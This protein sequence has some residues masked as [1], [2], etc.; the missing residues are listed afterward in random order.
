MDCF[1]IESSLSAGSPYEAGYR[2]GFVKAREM[3]AKVARSWA[4]RREIT[5]ADDI[6]EVGEEE[7]TP[8]SVS[9]K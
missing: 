6:L 4:D 8:S 5:D 3:A 7:V 9:V 1:G 2:A